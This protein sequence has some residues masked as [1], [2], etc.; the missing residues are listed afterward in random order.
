MKI[1]WKT[2]PIVGAYPPMVDVIAT[3]PAQLAGHVF[4]ATREYEE[5]KRIIQLFREVLERDG[6]YIQ[7]AMELHRQVLNH[8]YNMEKL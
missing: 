8:Q 2:D 3:V 7:G 5:S 4:R 6:G 1:D